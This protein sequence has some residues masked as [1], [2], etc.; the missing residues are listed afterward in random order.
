MYQNGTYVAKFN[1]VN[2]VD[3]ILSKYN[4]NLLPFLI[5]FIRALLPE[6][7]QIFLKTSP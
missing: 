6:E 2:N 7:F 4:S 1:F 3:L 5:I